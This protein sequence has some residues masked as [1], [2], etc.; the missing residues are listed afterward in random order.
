MSPHLPCYVSQ[1]A[2][3]YAAQSTSPLSTSSPLKSKRYHVGVHCYVDDEA[4][5]FG[6]NMYFETCFEMEWFG[7][8]NVFSIFH[9][10]CYDSK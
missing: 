5:K 4:Y 9:L 7:T 6:S 8:Q 2:Y 10:C 1:M 3:T